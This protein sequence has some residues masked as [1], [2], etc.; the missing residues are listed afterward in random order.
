M[1][2]L[3]LDI[4]AA[5]RR[6]SFYVVM[7]GLFGRTFRHCDW[8]LAGIALATAMAISIVLAAINSI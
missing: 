3:A 2:M 4:P 7:A 6:S 5:E 8:G 1:T